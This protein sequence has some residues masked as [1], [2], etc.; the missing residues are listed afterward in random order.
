MGQP[1]TVMSVATMP[2]PMIDHKAEVCGATAG[3]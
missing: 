1:K 3:G 2:V